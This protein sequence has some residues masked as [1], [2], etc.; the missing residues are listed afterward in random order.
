MLGPFNSSVVNPV[1]V[2]LA[3]HFHIPAA[4][5][6]YQTTTVIIVVGVA[7]LFWTPISNVYGRRPVFLVSSF[8]GII[9]TLGSGLAKT[10]GTLI[11][12]R[13]FSGVGVGAAMALGAATVNDMFFL[14]EVSHT[15]MGLSTESSILPD[16]SKERYKNGYL[17][18]IPYKYV[19]IST[20]PSFKNSGLCNLDGAHV[21][22]I[23][24]SK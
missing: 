19:Q 5:A 7:P 17:D 13:F 24:V 1:L 22:P 11:L 3:Q 6:S 10:W 9:A 21:G 8:I 12:A 20:I 15:I 14:H 16:R 23:I 2:P 4:S 18:R